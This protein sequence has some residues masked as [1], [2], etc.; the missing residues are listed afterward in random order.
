M[1]KLHFLL[2][3]FGC[4]LCAWAQDTGKKSFPEQGISFM[5]PSGFVGQ[6]LEQG[7]VLASQNFKGFVLMDTNDSKSVQEMRREAAQGLNDGQGTALYLQGSFDDLGPDRIGGVFSGTIGWQPAKAYIIGILNAPGPY[8]VTILAA[9]DEASFGNEV[10]DLARKI[11]AS[12][13]FTK[14]VEP[15]VD[16]EWKG[17]LSNVRLTYMSS[18]SS[19]NTGGMSSQAR[20]DLCANGRFTFSSSS[21]VSIDTGGAFGSSHGGD[22][23]QG[24][25]KVVKTSAGVS[26]LQLKFDDGRNWEYRLEYREKNVFL[27]GKRY[28]R[29]TGVDNPEY[30]PQC[31]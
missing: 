19:G 25:W 14:P 16:S 21:S 7:Y 28:F 18:Y 26:I 22:G 30:R 23:G 6:Q 27:D 8:G 11:A 10:V 1:N 15:A 29:T 31:Y 2:L 24:T 20:V 4:S 12:V 9:S 5:I 17:L 3:W 13:A